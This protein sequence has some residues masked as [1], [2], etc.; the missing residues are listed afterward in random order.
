L[1][2]KPKQP[3]S[4]TPKTTPTFLLE[5][6]LQVNGKQAKH[7]RGHFEAA[8][9]LYNA[10]LAEAVKRLH[11]MRAD[12]R[13]QEARLLPRT[14]KQER[15]AAFSAL[16]KAYGFSEY[17][18][19]AF[20]THANTSW[21]GD[22]LDS[23]TAQILATRAYRAT[24]RV[25]IGKAR[26]VRFKSKGRGLDSLEGKSN[27]AGIRFV[28]QAP[29]DGNSG[30]LVWGKEHIS[31]LLDWHD[32]VVCY[33]LR[34]RIK[35]ARLVRRKASSLRAHGADRAGYRY[36]AQ[37]AL[38]GVPYQKPKHPAGQDTVGLDV[39]PS[40]IAIVPKQGVARLETFCAEL[41]PDAKAKRRLE[42]KLDRQ[43]R[44]NNPQNYDEKGRCK[45][46]RQTWQESQGYKRTQRQLASQERKLAAHRKSLHGRLV[47]EVV[48]TGN[49]IITE[50]ISYKAWQKQ[51]GKSVGLRAPGM[52]LA[53]LKRTVASTGGTLSEVPTRQTKLSQYCHGCG[54]YQ[55]KPLSV[56]WHQCP[57]GI[58]PVQ[59]DLYSAFLV[60]HLN[61]KTFLPSI[62]QAVWESAETRLRAAIETNLQRAN[63]G[64]SLP[65][66]M[67]I[68]RAR[69][70]L[71]ESLGAV[72]QEL[73]LPLGS[74]ETLGH[75]QEPPR[76]YLRHLALEKHF[77]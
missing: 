6:P 71:P 34:H 21:I 14:Q 37:V 70:R 2:K 49:V 74:R 64:Q 51:Y 16:R 31:A 27:R 26:R 50:K 72:Q 23:N 60:A 1:N 40:T 62:A 41:T 42:R 32:P 65:R 54:T 13:W 9:Q 7:L 55:K 8:R 20:A 18:L 69:A 11:L 76:L 29:Q 75:L 5:L 33:G 77:M 44:A 46:G 61:L 53:L 17:A 66:S 28:L 73:C 43:R 39:G 3:A 52:F 15:Q 57:C 59:R 24:N 19:H 68:P 56:R 48:A 25:C 58:G 67:G 30:W 10:L 38:E 63:D 45:K 12:T 36:Y 4:N 35:Y 22:H 47:H